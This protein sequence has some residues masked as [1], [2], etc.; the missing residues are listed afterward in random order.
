MKPS[1]VEIEQSWTLVSTDKGIW[2]I[3]TQTNRC[4]YDDLYTKQWGSK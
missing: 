1:E 4:T 3:K 2:E